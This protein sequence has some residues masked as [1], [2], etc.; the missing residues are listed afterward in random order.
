MRLCCSDKRRPGGDRVLRRMM[1]AMEKAT[2][3]LRLDGPHDFE[4]LPNDR[5]EIYQRPYLARTPMRTVTQ[6][7]YSSCSNREK[8]SCYELEGF[9]RF[10]IFESKSWRPATDTSTI[11]TLLPKNGLRRRFWV[12]GTL[13][14]MRDSYGEV[15]EM[16]LMVERYP[17]FPTLRSLEEYCWSRIPFTD[18]SEEEIRVLAKNIEKRFGILGKIDVREFTL[19]RKLKVYKRT[20][21]KMMVWMLRWDM[22]GEREWGC[23][24]WK[25]YFQEH[26][27]GK[28]T[29]IFSRV[30]CHVY[31]RTW[32]VNRFPAPWR[33]DRLLKPKAPQLYHLNIT[34]RALT[35]LQ[36][37]NCVVLKKPAVLLSFED[38]PITG[39]P[40]D[41]SDGIPFEDIRRSFE[42]GPPEKL[43]RTLLLIVI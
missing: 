31:L 28:V 4:V 22:E 18:A 17:R 33:Y 40:E 16:S 23:S 14:G 34:R 10:L 3:Q 43:H 15:R 39:L 19:R 41:I 37:L 38:D 7:A 13:L 6:F 24:F 5:W 36:I 11:I 8:Q 12:N 42:F 2:K 1:A 25:A 20:G 35:W 26:P 9:L 30:A 27:G 32:I 29:F 21:N